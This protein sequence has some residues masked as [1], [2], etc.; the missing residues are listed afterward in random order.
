MNVIVNGVENRYQST[1][2]DGDGFSGAQSL[3]AQ[4][5]Y[6]RARD[7]A[8]WIEV[9]EQTENCME[10]LR[11]EVRLL[12]RMSASGLPDGGSY[13]ICMEKEL[14][15][16]QRNMVRMKVLLYGILQHK[17]KVSVR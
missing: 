11:S 10:K 16:L 6:S 4:P 9:F 12:G 3:K 7:E 14:A 13:S 1:N 5:R 17:S 15:E 8:Y 2:R